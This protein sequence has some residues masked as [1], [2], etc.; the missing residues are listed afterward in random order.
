[1][2]ERKLAGLCGL[3]AQLAPH[4]P[5]DPQQQH[6]AGLQQADHLQKLGRDAGKDDA[7]GGC[8]NDA[9]DDGAAALLGR[10]ARGSKADDHGVVAGQHEID[11]DDLEQRGQRVG[12]DEFKHV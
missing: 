6:A 5:A 7:Q 1:M 12:G 8:C 2:A 10:Q 4:L 9:D 3:L 11:Q